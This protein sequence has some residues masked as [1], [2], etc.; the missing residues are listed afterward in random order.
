M[1]QLTGMA[2]TLIT[3]NDDEAG[4]DDHLYIG[5]IGSGFLALEL[6]RGAAGEEGSHSG[7]V[8]RS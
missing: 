7:L 5:I 2:V 4:T 1:A 3:A 6:A 8:R